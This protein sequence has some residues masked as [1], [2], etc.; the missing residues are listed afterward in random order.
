MNRLTRFDAVMIGI[1][2]GATYVAFIAQ[3]VWR[4]L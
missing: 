4:P 1:M 3:F 2:L